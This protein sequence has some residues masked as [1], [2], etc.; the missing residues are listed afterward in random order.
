MLQK[1]AAKHTKSK[2]ALPTEMEWEWFARAGKG[3]SRFPWGNEASSEHEAL[4]GAQV[5]YKDEI[6]IPNI[7]EIRATPAGVRVGLF[8]PNQW[9]LYDVMGNVREITSDIISGKVWR[10]RHPNEPAS[11]RQIDTDKIVIKGSDR[12][13]G[14]WVGGISQNAY[15]VVWDGRNS[16]D[17]GVRFILID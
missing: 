2:V 16:A 6:A 1:L 7:Y 17:V 4:V 5:D 10:T 11:K 15:S 13:S 9:G 3:N 8:P 12:Y 14:D